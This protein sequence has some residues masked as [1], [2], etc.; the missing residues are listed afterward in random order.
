MGGP[1]LSLL[2]WWEGKG[3]HWMEKQPWQKPHLLQNTRLMS[4][5]YCHKILLSLP[6][7]VWL[8]YYNQTEWKYPLLL[9]TSVEHWASFSACCILNLFLSKIFGR[10]LLKKLVSWYDSACHRNFYV[11]IL[12]YTYIM[13]LC[14]LSSRTVFSLYVRLFIR[15]SKY[16][17]HKIYGYRI[18]LVL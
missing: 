11:S 12:W 15:I 1:Q 2:S 13:C 10:A 8:Q 3:S 7:T 14:Q 18:F 17:P 4:E 5:S 6:G 9:C 16:F